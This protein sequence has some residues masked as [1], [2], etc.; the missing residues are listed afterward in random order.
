MI[1]WSLALALCACGKKSDEQ[2]PSAPSSNPSSAAPSPAPPGS[3]FG[4]CDDIA[5]SSICNEVVA[6][7]PASISHD[8]I[9]NGATWHQAC[10]TEGH[11]GAC[12]S[13]AGAI[14]HYYSTGPEKFDAVKA[15]N[16]CEEGRG[17]WMP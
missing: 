8:Q 6:K 10:P 1:A 3:S 7:I 13:P 4:A 12:N 14:I 2:T 9:C 16:N 17:K 5:K 15:K 11:V